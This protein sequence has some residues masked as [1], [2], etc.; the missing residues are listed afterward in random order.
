MPVSYPNEIESP[1]GTGFDGTMD[2]EVFEATEPGQFNSTQLIRTTQDWAIRVYWEMH[3]AWPPFGWFDFDVTAFYES[4]GAGPEGTL[5][6]VT[7]NSLSV[8][9]AGGQRVYGTMPVV[10]IPVL[11]GTLPVGLYNLAVALQPRF[12]GGPPM[13]FAGL[14]E[15]KPVNIFA[16]A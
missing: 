6:A 4:I 10:E 1:T 14:V 3:G 15:L 16:P 13:P 5:G 2:A 11:A 12:V 9:L 8:P 7:V